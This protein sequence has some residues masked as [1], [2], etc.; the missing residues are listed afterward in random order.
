[1]LELAGA[2]PCVLHDQRA[3]SAYRWQ[4]PR[5]SSHITRPERREG[6]P[7]WVGPALRTDV[8]SCGYRGCFSGRAATRGPGW[9]TG[10]CSSSKG[11]VGVSSIRAS[12]GSSFRTKP[13]TPGRRSPGPSRRCL[14]DARDWRQAGPGRMWPRDLPWHESGAAD[15]AWGGGCRV[16]AFSGNQG[17]CAA[18]LRRRMVD[19]APSLAAGDEHGSPQ[20]RRDTCFHQMALL[21]TDVIDARECI[22]QEKCRC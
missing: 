18:R 13:G 20:L 12:T 8:L 3:T 10:S 19:G 15:R 5:S 6:F 9:K 2:T 22:P 4:E 14:G 11:A 16:P 7:V 17:L 1:M 21:R